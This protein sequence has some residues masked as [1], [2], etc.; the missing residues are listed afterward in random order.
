MLDD[1]SGRTHHCVCACCFAKHCGDYVTKGEGNNNDLFSDYDYEDQDEEESNSVWYSQADPPR[2][3]WKWQPNL[4]HGLLLHDPQD[5][6]SLLKPFFH[7]HI[8]PSFVSLF[9][10]KSL[11]LAKA[12]WLPVSISQS[13]DKVMDGDWLAILCPELFSKEVWSSA[14]GLS[15]L[16]EIRD[17]VDEVLLQPLLAF[18][19]L[20][21]GSRKLSYEYEG[22]EF[23]RR[24]IIK[25]VNLIDGEGD[26]HFLI[27]ASKKLLNLCE[28][29]DSWRERWRVLRTTNLFKVGHNEISDCDSA[30]EQTNES[31]YITSHF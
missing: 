12:N 13:E 10:W 30:D 19:Y 22:Q 29:H 27:V 28:Y 7:K 1:D 18:Q 3:Q 31:P 9:I 17:Y 11:C 21:P 2:T 23:R 26:R 15:R 5:D 20:L 25:E 14:S 8:K 16:K 4:W 6:I 24:C